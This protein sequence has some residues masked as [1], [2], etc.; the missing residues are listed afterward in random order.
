MAWYV[1]SSSGDVPSL[2]IQKHSYRSG[3]VSRCTGHAQVRNIVDASA[4]RDIQD[5]SAYTGR[6]PSA[7]R[8]NVLPPHADLAACV[9]ALPARVRMRLIAARYAPTCIRARLCRPAP[10]PPGR[11]NSFPAPASHPRDASLAHGAVFAALSRADD[12]QGYAL[13][14]I[15]RKLYYCV[16]CAAKQRCRDA[17]QSLS[18]LAMQRICSGRNW[19]SWLGMLAAPMSPPASR[20]RLSVATPC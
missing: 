5:S 2:Y 18:L 20:A 9:H 16:R 12:T 7:S 6:P 10:L 8:R 1:G 11:G 17:V 4:I 14:K 13:P 19:P 3:N 15:Y